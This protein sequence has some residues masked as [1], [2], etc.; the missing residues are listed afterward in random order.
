MMNRLETIAVLL[1]LS[2][3]SIANAA[4]IFQISPE[5]SSITISSTGSDQV[6]WDVTNN[7]SAPTTIF[8]NSL[9]GSGGSPAN[10]TA[11]LKILEDTC[12]NIVTPSGAGCT[13]TMGIDGATLT[14]ATTIVS[15]VFCGFHGQ[16]CSQAILANRL[17]IYKTSTP[18]G[19]TPSGSWSASAVPSNLTFPEFLSISGN[20][21]AVGGINSSYAPDV[22]TCPIATPTTCTELN[23]GITAAT[24][25][26]LD[27]DGNGNLFGVF[28]AQNNNDAINPTTTSVMVWKNNTWSSYSPTL[29]GVG[30][31]LNTQS[32]L[33]IL[34]SSAYQ[35]PVVGYGYPSFGSA[36]L[37]NANGTVINAQTNS[38]AANLTAIVDDGLG[39]VYVAGQ[40]SNYSIIPTPQPYSLIWRWNTQS[41]NPLTAFTPIVMPND[42][43]TITSMVSDGKGTLYISG[44]DNAAVGHVWS[45][46]N[47]IFSDTGL[48][49]ESVTTLEYSP[50]GYLLAGGI[51]NINYNGAVWYYSG[52]NWTNLNLPSSASVV[53]IGANS[54][55][56]IVT[57]NDDTY[58]PKIWIYQ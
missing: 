3:A 42:L 48:I 18:P 10:N 46:R 44:L 14:S 12:S 24:I 43:P 9:N 47:G 35:I 28:V 56:I 32:T 1:G 30:F 23:N 31:G 5:I 4:G 53:S 8:L 7:T 27:Y 55:K 19:P 51:D 29:Q 21:F 38:D 11:G 33:G 54:S 26:Q 49:A 15:P 39:N 22:W 34:A 36:Q 17:T 41:T 20:N 13:L 52:G 50:G 25:H 40:V 45:Y 58:N 16:A 2:T 37:Y 6:V 57:G